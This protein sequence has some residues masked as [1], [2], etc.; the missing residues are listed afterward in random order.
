MAKINRQTLPFSSSGEYICQR[1]LDLYDDADCRTLGTQATQGRR[2]R[3][4]V[5]EASDAVLVQQCEDQYQAWLPVSQLTHLVPVDQPYRAIAVSRPEIEQRIPAI[6]EY[7]KQAQTKSNHYQWG[8]NIGPDYDCSGLM[9]A[10]FQSQGIWLP[11]DSYQQAAFCQTVVDVRD[12][13]LVTKQQTMRTTMADCLLGDLLFFGS[14]RIDH[15]ALYLGG[16]KYCH[17]SGQSKG[18]NGIAEDSLWE[19]ND[20]TRHHYFGKWW[21]CGRVTH[22]FIPNQDPLATTAI[23]VDTSLLT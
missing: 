11:R 10:A 7:C 1:H 3:L 9:Q 23:A 19:L 14:Q 21:Q 22:S 13:P 5:Q 8:G 15:V 12:L 18:R 16:G 4:T 17:S 6:I 20:A 2:L